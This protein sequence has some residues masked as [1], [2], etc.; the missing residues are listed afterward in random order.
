MTMK[1]WILFAVF[2]A[3]ILGF[4][5]AISRDR[6]AYIPDDDSHRGVTEVSVCRRCHAAGTEQALSAEHPPKDQCLECH[7]RKK[8]RG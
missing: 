1:N 3:L 6:A 4:F 8:K 5:L 7:K 2:V